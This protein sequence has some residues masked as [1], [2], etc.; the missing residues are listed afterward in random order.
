[1]LFYR[2]RLRAVKAARRGAGSGLMPG[3][4]RALVPLFLLNGSKSPACGKAGTE[5]YRLNLVNLY[6]RPTEIAKFTS[7]CPVRGG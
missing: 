6:S 4:C 1:M 3:R 5:T 7:Y 2:E